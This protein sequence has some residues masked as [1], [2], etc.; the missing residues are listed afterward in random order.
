MWEV[1]N[2]LT[3]DARNA[4]KAKC[5]ELN[6]DRDKGEIS[7]DEAFIN[8]TSCV[9]ILSE[10]IS[11]RKLIQFPLTVQKELLA[12]SET[13]S[14]FL[15]ALT[16]GA[17]EVVNLIDA[18]EQLNA[19]VWHHRLN[20]M[21]G[22]LLGFESKINQLKIQEVEIN[23]IHEKL[24]EALKVNE[25]LPEVLRILKSQ[26]KLTTDTLEEARSAAEKVTETVDA[27]ADLS[28]KAEAKTKSAEEHETA[29]E[30]HASS[31]RLSLAEIEA[32]EAKIKVFY[33]E[34]DDYREKITS[35]SEDAGRSVA[36]NKS[37]TD[38]LIS[39]LAT[40]EKQIQKQI[41]DATGYSLFHSFQTRQ[42]NIAEAKN[43]W[44]RALLALLLVSIG[45]TIF[46]VLSIGASANLDVAFFLKLS[47]S[48]P[49]I[50]AITFCTVQYSRERRL[51][52]EYAFKSAISISLDPYQKLVSTIVDKSN[53]KE[54]EEFTK[55]ILDAIQKVFTS[56]TEKIF[57]PKEKDK[58]K[59]EKSLKQVAEIAGSFAKAAKS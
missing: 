4:A 31:S 22:K 41:Q 19:A 20:N 50:G 57:D 30:K 34:V 47:I 2:T 36:E 13:I 59:L 58:L 42:G 24:N 38:K 28:K 54:R 3:P 7:W 21:S 51:E 35:T 25:Q 37:Q 39:D 8:L 29:A 9:N 45:F 14:R 46:L 48:I 52:E 49:I 53:E 17:D 43:F 23:K 5:D 15:I 12:K 56:P 40:L 33:S 1:L 26:Q 27:V 16:N 18:I 55:F 11:E 32:I 6:F 10:A 44:G